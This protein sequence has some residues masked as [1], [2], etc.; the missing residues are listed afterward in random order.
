[1]KKI[2]SI[3]LFVCLS[4]LPLS[5]KS[6]IDLE[7]GAGAW[8]PTLG[9]HVKYSDGVATGTKIEFD[10]MEFEKDTGKYLY[11]DF[12]HFVPVL[13]NIRIEK[14]DYKIVGE[15]TNIPVSFG[16]LNYNGDVDMTVDMAQTDIIMYW[17]LPF[18]STATGGVFDINMGLDAKKY[19][20]SILLEQKV[21]GLTINKEEAVVDQTLPLIYLNFVLDIPFVPIKLDATTKFVSYDGAKI[22]DNSFKLSYKL[23]FSNALVDVNLDLGYRVQNI[24]IPDSLVDNLDLDMDTKGAF[25]GVSVKF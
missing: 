18:I 23:P 5:A 25:Y 4:S 6:G 7:L 19:D 21:L 22:S 14:T 3:V 12:N 2:L 17:S 24:T 1:M 13:P 9:G 15:G 11:L 10:D 16:S 20:G 8:T